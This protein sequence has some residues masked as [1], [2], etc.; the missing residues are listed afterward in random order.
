MPAGLD[1]DHQT[2]L[3]GA[4]AV[5]NQHILVATGQSDWKSRIEDEDGTQPWSSVVRNLKKMLGPKGEYHSV[6]KG[7]DLPTVCSG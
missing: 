1:I 7:L 6:S 3:S 4:M 5:Y 2:N